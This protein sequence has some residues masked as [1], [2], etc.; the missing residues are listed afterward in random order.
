MKFVHVKLLVFFLFLLCTTPLTVSANAGPSYW[1]GYPSYE[2]L[3]VDK[4]CP[5]QVKSERLLFDLSADSRSSY[6]VQGQVTAAYRMLNPTAN[7]LAVQM[8][9]PL[10]SSPAAFSAQ[11][12][13]VT[14][15]DRDVP[16]RLYLGNAVDS[17]GAEGEEK[18][19]AFDDILATVTN[20]PYQPE[21]FSGQETGQLYSLEV[22]PTTDQSIHLVVDFE[23]DPDKTSILTNGFSRF[24]RHGNLVR[25]ASRCYEPRRLEIFVIGAD[26]DFKTS[27]Y[28]DGQLQQRTNLYSIHTSKG[29]VALRPYL[30]SSLK[31]WLEELAAETGTT[32]PLA[33]TFSEQQ[34]YDLYA[35]ALDRYLTGGFCELQELHH[36]LHEE[37]VLTLVYDVDFPA[38]STRKVNV[39]SNTV[40]TMDR[41]KTAHPVYTFTH[42]LNP[43]RYWNSFGS[44]TIDISTPPEAPHVIASNLDLTQIEEQRYTTTVPSLPDHDFVF[45]IYAHKSI[46]LLDRITGVFNASFEYSILLVVGGIILAGMVVVLTG[47]TRFLRHK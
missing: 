3:A 21:H 14:V 31:S 36:V 16:Y 40:A 19:L 2:V 29:K 22:T 15:D 5:L 41:R 28:I 13:T 39:T 32:I 24:E 4:D 26:I 30:L 18:N 27:A 17:Y 33:R 35:S 10:I 7:D 45:S 23:F 47:L 34:L 6:T 12:V 43:A 1:H 25:V 11:N 44:L 20:Q 37:R 8:A 42:I 46:S 38:R 9:F